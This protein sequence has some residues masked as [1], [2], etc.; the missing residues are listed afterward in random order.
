[1]PPGNLPVE[2]SSFVGRSR[3]LSEVKR[4]LPAAPRSR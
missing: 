3:E 1:M 2:L 4:L